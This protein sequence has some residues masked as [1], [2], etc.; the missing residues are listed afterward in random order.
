MR[1]WGDGNFQGGFMSSKYPRGSEWRKWDLH[2]HSTCGTPEEITE[3]MIEMGVSVFSITDHSSVDEVDEFLELSEKKRKDGK[4]IYFLPGIELR[5]DKGKKSVHIIGIFS[6]FD[7]NL[8]QIN[9]EYLK[10]NL[11]SKINC[12][13]ADIINAGRDVLGEGKTD[14]EYKERGKKE[15]VVDF[16][17]VSD[18]IREIGGIVIVH[19]GTKGSGIEK[20]MTHAKKNS[21][22]ELYNSLGHTKRQLMI[23]YIDV[24]ELP[25]WFKQNLKERDFY[26]TKFNKPSI[27]CSDSH[28]LS[29]IGLRYTWIKANPTFDGLRQII[30]EPKLRVVLNEK[31]ELYLYPRLVSFRLREATNY[32]TQTD[33][34][35]FPP[36]NLTSEIFFSENLTSIIG[37]R[38][39]GKTVLVE[40]LSYLFDKHSMEPKNEKS[41]LISYL[42]K[43]FP[44][45]IVE[46]IYQC[47]KKDP[48]KASRKVID[49]SDPFYT[50][51][52]N[53][54]YWSQ[55]EIEKVADRKEKIADYIRIRLES[56]LLLNL[57]SKIEKLE[58]ELADVRN[59]YF[60]KFEIK[61]DYNN[62]LAE[63]KQIEEYFEKLKT[64]EYM[65][66][67][68][69]IQD[70]RSKIELLDILL[71]N[72][73]N[74]IDLL[75]ESY[76]Q[77][78]FLDFPDIEVFGE[79]FRKSSPIY[80]EIKNLYNFIETA[81]EKTIKRFIEFK[82]D[83][84]NSKERTEL[85]KK[86]TDLKKQFIAYCEKY[87]IK[88]TKSEYENR[89]SRLKI[90]TRL[91]REKEI[92]LKEYDEAKITH[93][94]LAKNLQIAL[95]EW[96][97]ENNKIIKEFN[98][99]CANSNIQ[100]LWED[101]SDILLDWILKQFLES[102]GMTK[103]L[104]K[105]HYHL[106]SP[107][108]G[109]FVKDF[110]REMIEDKKYTREDIVSFLKNKKIPPLTKS[111][112]KEENLKWFFQYEETKILRDDLIMRLY[113]YSER[114]INLIK[115]KDKILG[116]STMSF[117]ERCGTLAELI[118]FSG[119]HP[120]IIDQPEEHL[121][122]TFI[123]KRIVPL[124]R[125]QKLNRQIIICTHNPNI[126]VLGDSELVTVLSVDDS[127]TN[128]VQGALEDPVIRTKIYDVLEGG[129]EAFRKREQKYGF[130]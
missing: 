56:M 65:D 51:P 39:S 4:E 15:K 42:A 93:D 110:L 80:K 47:G 113:E 50:A 63:K 107:V 55:G 48:E 18:K 108:R 95:R 119:D 68:N 123:A 7:K 54:E 28:K 59:K 14:V 33:K 103:L 83:I 46:T 117:G 129:L 52:I 71:E 40:M 111:G 45:L 124:L 1:C 24:C 87:G 91:L 105:K 11:L 34:N 109:D 120:L 21:D 115:Y 72:I 60:K 97:E 126:T 37:P 10:Q 121:D 64:R 16:E 94:R 104:I 102:D 78:S 58:V 49:L 101:P 82:N 85:L 114:G 3:K 20:E 76:K 130:K 122:A 88:I 74:T 43:K 66:L 79:I 112:G 118:L 67:T 70:N 73:Q 32:Q 81:R 6:L 75:E 90:V 27:I 41:P 96:K 116:K 61:I 19:A 106:S 5:T 29:D 30:Y 125:E 38:A 84:V 100:V 98:Q 127:G 36:I 53:I 26:L 128:A 69:E 57:I 13:D 92:K 17:C 77:L 8:A 23:K 22:Y 2:V 35:E 25:N 31:P 44:K 86:G 89:T 62:L 9:T 99:A 12:S